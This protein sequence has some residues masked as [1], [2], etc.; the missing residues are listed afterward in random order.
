MEPA[1]LNQ[2][3]QFSV[4]NSTCVD[5]LPRSLLVDQLGLVEPDR[6]SASGVVVGIADRA[7]RGVNA[8]VDQALREGKTA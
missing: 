5:R 1:W 6:D 3:T 7:D 2:S 4:A 8:G